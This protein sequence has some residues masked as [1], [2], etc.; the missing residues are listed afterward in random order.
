[1]PFNSEQM[2]VILELT[3]QKL[4]ALNIANKLAPVLQ[5]LGITYNTQES[6]S[7]SSESE[8]ADY[9]NTRGK[10]LIIGDSKV[11]KNHIEGMLK[12]EFELDN[13]QIVQRFEFKL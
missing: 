6:L 10:I 11:K 5:M 4:Y 9:V 13:L 7:D 2:N 1:M 8:K 12:K 3:K